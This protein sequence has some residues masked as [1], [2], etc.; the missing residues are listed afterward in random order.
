MISN[1]DPASEQF[2]FNLDRIQQQIAT[3]N[4]QVSSGKRIA[5]ASDAPDQ[6]DPLLQLRSDR[7]L[8]SQLQSNLVLAKAEAGGA[9]TALSSAINLMDNALT[10][11]EQGTDI[12]ETAVTRQSLA[13]QVQSI[14]EQMVNLSQTAVQA[15]YIFS[16]DATATP[17]YT[18]DINSPDNAV[19]QQTTSAATARVAD[20][21]GGSFAASKTAQQIFD[22]QN[23]DGTSA[24]DNVF[25]ALNNLRLALLAND[26]SA[27]TNAIDPIK[28]ASVHLNSMQSFYGNVENRIQTATDFASSRDTQL[29]TQ[30]SGIE[31]ADVTAAALSLTSANTQLQAAMEMRAKL[32]Q[33]TLFN[34]L[35]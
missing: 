24:T 2:L 17:P 33:T 13:D 10:L 11:A 25:A 7:A 4:Q 12:N 29:Q 1:L 16:G 18:F 14:Q 22:D 20:P 28:Q 26:P 3:A 15:R 5:A 6:I 34:Y 19:V 23:P 21:A 32:P 27:I 30:I 31:D 9:D 8:N 35:G